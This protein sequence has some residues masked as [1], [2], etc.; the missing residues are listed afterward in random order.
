MVIYNQIEDSNDQTLPGNNSVLAQVDKEVNSI[1]CSELK[2]LYPSIPILSGGN[3]EIPFEERANWKYCFS[4][5]PLDGPKGFMRKN[6]EFTINIGLCEDGEP[7]LG[8]IVAPATDPPRMYY[9]IRGSGYPCVEE[10]GDSDVNRS[11]L[12]I[13]CKEFSL[14][15][16]GLTI[17][18]SASYVSPETE[19]FVQQFKNP[20]VR[21]FG[22]SLTLLLIAEGKA[23]I[24]PHFA[25]TCEWQICAAQAIVEAA[26]GEVL[27]YNG[28]LKDSSMKPMKYNKMNLINPS[29][30]VF[31]A[32]TKKFG[33][34]ERQKSS[35]PIKLFSIFVL[36]LSI[37][38]FFLFR[39]DIFPKVFL[40]SH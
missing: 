23:D 12:P 26:G 4:V 1:I 2:K 40:H 16:E 38:I 36:L 29:L 33:R 28:K 17:I 30:I 34:K 14:A 10:L 25:P 21:E 11:L 32:S 27:E 31:G 24:Y 35:Q 8:L 19:Q 7:V 39:N 37:S 9:A 3:Q 5:D 20:K 18:T 15:D 22:S 6:G 13:H